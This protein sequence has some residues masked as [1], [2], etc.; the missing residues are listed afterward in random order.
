MSLHGTQ[1]SFGRRARVAAGGSLAWSVSVVVHL[2]LV[3]V[4]SRWTWTT[5]EL[6]PHSPAAVVWLAS[7]PQP[8]SPP[9]IEPA[10]AEPPPSPEVE[11][12]PAPVGDLSEAVDELESALPESEPAPRVAPDDEDGDAAPTVTET[13]PPNRLRPDIDWDAERHTAITSVLE[14][15]ERE[16][17]YRTFSLADVLDEEP[18]PPAEPAPARSY[19][20]P[21]PVVGSRMA[22]FAMMLV[23]RC[24]RIEARDDMF[25]HIKPAHLD[26]R[27]LCTDVLSS[28]ATERAADRRDAPEP[29]TLTAAATA[30][31]DADGVPLPPSFADGI[32]A[33]AASTVKCR[34]ATEAEIARFYALDPSVLDASVAAE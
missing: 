19:F 22:K 6:E 34:L 2:V 16:Q 32:T 25:A 21:C 14:E 24:A 3:Y 23:G 18:A 8:R 10:P 12:T 31:F 20:E 4:A 27:P 29:D 1:R 7:L 5:T 13:A 11:P 33:T 9:P 26:M 17:S 30:S 15:R 28:A